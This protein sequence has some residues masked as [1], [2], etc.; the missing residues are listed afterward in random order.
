M[1]MIK[2]FFGCMY[3]LA[4]G[5][6]V[7]TTVEF[8]PRG[9]F[10]PVTDMV[11]GGPFSLNPGQWTDDTSMALCLAESLLECEGFHIENQMNKYM[12]W[13][14]EGYLSSTGACFDI[15]NTVLMAL[16]K[17]TKTNNLLSGP[18][19][20]YSAGNG[21]IMRLAPVAL[22]YSFD[23]KE[24]LDRCANSSRT[25]HQAKE[26]IDACQLFGA[27]LYGALQGLP[28]EELL[29][30]S[31]IDSVKRDVNVDWSP[32]IDEVAYGS[33]KEKSSELIEG[34]GYVVKTLEAVLWAF[35]HTS[36]FKEGLL[37]VVNLG[38][39]ADTTGAVY[40][41]LAGAFYGFSSIP[42]KWEQKLTKRDLIFDYTNGLFHLHRKF[43][44]ENSITKNVNAN[45]VEVIAQQGS[46][47]YLLK[48]ENQQG[49]ILDLNENMLY[50]PVFIHSILAR[51]YW[52]EYKDIIDLEIVLNKV[53][54]LH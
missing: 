35:Y 34:S 39:D 9:S 50:P 25:T 27:L 43:V 11:G 23:M 38:N 30:T 48:V 36:T 8:K 26:A 14:Q 28:K 31:F 3:G 12:K 40:G 29:S 54:H 7:G 18:S 46:G 44:K 37:K 41:Q 1:E 13:M 49:R 20:K 22:L 10:E 4:V 32:A 17:Y 15:G 42:E 51:G 21:S 45:N 5:D 6:A 47:R 53:K 52:E 16:N 19:N 33:Y 2:R 24:C